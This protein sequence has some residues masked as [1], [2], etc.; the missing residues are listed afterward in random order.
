MG[1]NGSSGGPLINVAGEVVREGFPE[2]LVP[3]LV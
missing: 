3:Q 1:G 2:K